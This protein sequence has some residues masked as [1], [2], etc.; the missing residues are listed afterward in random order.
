MSA[1]GTI[2][3]DKRAIYFFVLGF[4]DV[5]ITF[6]TSVQ[7]NVVGPCGSDGFFVE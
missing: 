2:F 1:D 3:I 6:R 4:I 7:H 5:P